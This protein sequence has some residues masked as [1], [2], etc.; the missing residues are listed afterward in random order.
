MFGTDAFKEKLLALAGRSIEQSAKRRNYG[1][2]EAVRE[3]HQQRAESLL[4]RG[5]EVCGL[6]PSQLGALPCGDERKGVIALAIKRET[7]VPLDWI[8]NQLKM[9]TRGTVSRVTGALAERVAKH[10]KLA[11]QYK[12]IVNGTHG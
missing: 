9:G 6:E 8:G 7:T 5:L 10:S 3:H 2:G 1:A 12:S 11:K 4:R